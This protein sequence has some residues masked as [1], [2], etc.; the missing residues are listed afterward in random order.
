MGRKKKDLTG[1]K[2]GRLTVIKEVGRTK[3]GYVLWECECEC[4]TKKD[5]SSATL[6]SGEST[7]C[8]C[9]WKSLWTKHGQVD[10]DLYAVWSMMKQRCYNENNKDYKHYGLRGITICDEW[11]SDFK[12]FYGWSLNNNYKKGL[13][14]D[15]KNNDGNYEPSN[16]RW[17]TMKV[18]SKNKR[19]VKSS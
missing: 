1:L 7:S 11:R 18:Q 13:T 9:Y 2:F 10:S 4:G 12:S 15:R 8:G 3:H 19:I 14:I 6:N 17:V 5:I 16:C